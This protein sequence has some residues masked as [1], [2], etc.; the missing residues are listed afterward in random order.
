M[1]F[2]NVLSKKR[3]AVPTPE[4]ICDELGN[5]YFGTFDKEFPK[6]DFLK[7]N[8]PSALPNIFNKFRLTLWEATEIN[9]DK[10][11]LLTAVCDM[12]LFG[13]ALTVIYDKR[14]KKCTYWKDMLLPGKAVIS[15]TLINSS[16]TYSRSKKV[17][18]RYVNNFQRGEAVVAGYASDKEAGVIDYRVKLTRVS[19][20]SVVSIPFDSNRPLYTQ[21]DLFKVEGYVEVNGERFTADENTAAIIDDHRGYY[22]RHSHYDWVTTMGKK[23]I[24]GKE[25][26]FGFNLTRNQS[27]NQDDY[28]ENLIWFEGDT[29][30][31]TPVVFKHKSDSVWN[32]RDTKGMVDV[33]FV[34]GDE[35]VMKMKTGI[36]NTDYHI[37]FGELKGYVCDPDGNK[38]ILDGMAGIGEDKTVVW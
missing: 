33:T 23:E 22:P 16:E 14:T 32:I 17:K 38:Y 29:T 13:T 5:C 27:I 18:I 10:I 1:D 20:P 31:L 30:L 8:K 9:F 26:F 6:M 21:K 12:G 15:D 34:I 7:I 36:L 24:D 19:K 3:E 11:I 28:N 37:T 2:R 4:N 25:Q 35:F